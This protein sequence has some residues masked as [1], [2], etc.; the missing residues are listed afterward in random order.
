MQVHRELLQ[1]RQRMSR[2]DIWESR[3]LLWE[4][5]LYEPTVQ[6]CVGIIEA[7]CLANGVTCVIGGAKCTSE[8]EAFVD[9]HYVAFCKRAIRAFFAYGFVPWII[10]KDPLGNDLP[11][12]LP[13]GTFHWDTV[14]ADSQG[15][16]LRGPVVNYKVELVH[17]VN[18]LEKDVHIY[19]Y[20]P[21]SLGVSTGSFLNA[22][23]VSPMSALLVGYKELRQAMIRRSYADAWNTTAK[24]ICTYTPH[25]HVQDEPG[26]ALM[27]FADDG[28]YGAGMNLGVPIMP[29]LG[30]SN[31]ETRDIQIRKQFEGVGTHL[32]DVFTLPKD[33]GIAPQM[34]LQG[35]DDV[36]FLWDKFRRE[37]A[38]ITHVP[39]EMIQSLGAGSSHETVRK[40]ASSG[41]IF[42]SNMRQICSHLEFLLK[43]VY[44]TIYRKENGDARF[45]LT[46]VR[47]MEVECIGDI[48]TLYEVGV[49]TAKHK[50]DV[51]SLLEDVVVV[52]P[53]RA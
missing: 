28:Y 7:T 48:K 43:D 50:M 15:G 39:Y 26:A 31:L 32:P 41:K 45:L 5:M 34:I 30:A 46:P 47:R 4:I 2:M 49:L 38:S 33:H 37:T 25:T 36:P 42:S 29:R 52:P 21:A 12:V 44:E 24:L 22:T 27:D 19:E 20:V 35:R 9:R 40:T 10:R 8:F 53:R 18:V 16:R 13:E 17:N 14:A 6:E 11:E 23:I 1:A 3:Q 51:S